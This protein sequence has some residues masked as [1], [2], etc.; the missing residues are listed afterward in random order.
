VNCANCCLDLNLE[1]IHLFFPERLDEAGQEF[2]RVRGLSKAS[3]AS[4]RHG[5]V[6]LPNGRVRLT[7]RCQQ[8]LPDNRCGIY[9]TRPQICRDFDCST[10]EDHAEMPDFEVPVLIPLRAVH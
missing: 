2:L 8:L 4:L 7:H 10:R 5:A 3:L 9:E 1:P 6:E